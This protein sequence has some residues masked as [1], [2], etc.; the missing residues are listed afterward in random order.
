ML[1]QYI[2]FHDNGLQLEWV[3]DLISCVMFYKQTCPVFLL[4][5]QINKY[6]LWI[7]L[8]A[9]LEWIILVALWIK[10]LQKIK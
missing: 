3:H 8:I 7:I 9:F 4:K 1:R 6:R 5:K 2:A 10:S